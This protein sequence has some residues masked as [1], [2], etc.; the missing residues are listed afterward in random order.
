MLLCPTSF[1]HRPD[2][3]MDTR[4]RRNLQP[5]A[6]S[7]VASSCQQPV[8]L[9]RILNLP[10]ARLRNSQQAQGSKTSHEPTLQLPPSSSSLSSLPKS[11]AVCVKPMFGTSITVDDVIE[12][13]EVNRAFGADLFYFYIEES[14]QPQVRDCLLNYE[15]LGY[16]ETT[17]WRLPPDIDSKVQ[18]KGQM[19]TTTEC[20]YRLMYRTEYLTQIDVDEFI[21]PMRTEDWRSMLTLIDSESGID[22]KKIASYSFRNR[23]IDPK[24]PAIDP[25]TPNIGLSEQLGQFRDR[26]RTLTRFRGENYLYPWTKRSK[27]MARPE[28]VVIWHVHEIMDHHVVPRGEKNLKINEKD[29]VMQHYRRDRVPDPKGGVS[30]HTRLHRFARKIVEHLKHGV[31]VCSQQQ[32][33][34]VV[35][36]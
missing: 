22:A 27:V 35:E 20:V 23:F 15:R 9:I 21:V 13:I 11:F 4:D 25:Q 24:M 16:V 3:L 36:R 18:Y 32:R 17:P 6:V 26:F 28:R 29:G 14:I 19:L 12:F 8:N 31:S 7:V 33:Q 10:A 34:S 2:D 30:N 1:S 5:H